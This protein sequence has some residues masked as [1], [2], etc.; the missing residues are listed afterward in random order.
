MAAESDATDAGR[1][2][3]ERLA[4]IRRQLQGFLAEA[5]ELIATDV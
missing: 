3:V 4:A 2:P 1:N 5:T